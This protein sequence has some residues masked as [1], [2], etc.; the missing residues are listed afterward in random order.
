[1]SEG[2]PQGFLGQWKGALKIVQFKTQSL[3]SCGFN[4]GILPPYG[5]ITAPLCGECA[6]D[7]TH[8]VVNTPTTI[9]PH[10]EPSSHIPSHEVSQPEGSYSSPVNL[11]SVISSFCLV[12]SFWL[13]F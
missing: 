12:M 10:P 8:H 13:F 1:M 4:Y 7:G 9:G 6:G 5:V 3:H 11:A 2:V